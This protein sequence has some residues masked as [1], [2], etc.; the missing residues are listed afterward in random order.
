M[1]RSPVQQ[2]Q[3]L[4]AAGL[5]TDYTASYLLTRPGA[6]APDRVSIYRLAAAIR[7]D[8]EGPTGTAIAIITTA[9]ADACEVTAAKTSCFSVTTHPLPS[10]LDP[11]LE[12]VFSSYLA[13]LAAPKA[14]GYEVRLVGRTAAS[15]V[16]PAGTCFQVS[17]GPGGATA[18][19]SG[20]YCLAS[21]GVPTLVS[22]SAGQLQMLSLSGPPAASVLTPPAKPTPLP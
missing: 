1:T 9:G 7:V 16:R 22:Y 15:S 21:D 19:A 3:R 6:T 11:G 12:R 18:V 10:Y 20:R 4:A 5:K 8:I 17:G 2:L 14:G 13:A